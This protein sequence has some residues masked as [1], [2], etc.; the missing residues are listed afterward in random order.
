MQLQ[1]EEH[2]FQLLLRFIEDD[3]SPEESKQVLQWINA[4][5]ENTTY[6]EELK[7][8]YQ[9][10]EEIEDFDKIDVDRQWEVFSQN[11]LNQSQQTKS[12]IS[13]YIKIAAAIVVLLGIGFL[14]PTQFNNE[15]TLIAGPD[16]KTEFLLPDNSK[17]WLNKGSELTYSKSDFNQTERQVTLKGEAFFEVKK[18]VLK[19]FVVHTNQTK[20]KVLGT[21]FN[22]KSDSSTGVTELMLLTG[23]VSFSSDSDSVILVP[24]EKAKFVKGKKIQKTTSYNLNIPAWK[25]GVLMFDQTPLAQVLTDLETF[26]DKKITIQNK[27][28]EKC[29]LTSTF[30]NQS[31]NSVLEELV[32]LFNF[33]IAEPSPEVIQLQDGSCLH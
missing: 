23:S 28:L 20:T 24:G 14:L 12:S 6:F 21:S 3:L 32:L 8:T 19:P 7:Q 22:L 17:I 29:K 9:N 27:Q 15:V 5:E 18:D 31:L 4:S 11:N 33:T 1:P 30:D 25:S 26:Y 10:A 16:Q 13:F 2:I